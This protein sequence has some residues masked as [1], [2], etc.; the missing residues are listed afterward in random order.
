[1]TDAV[2]EMQDVRMVFTS[3]DGERF[4]A[5]DGLNMAVDEGHGVVAGRI[6]R[7]THM[8]GIGRAD[9]DLRAVLAAVRVE[10]LQQQA[11]GRLVGGR[12][13]AVAL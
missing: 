8:L 5:V 4:T 9:G 1:M 13:G 6:D 2:V 7:D 11:A 3:V 10:P 12:K